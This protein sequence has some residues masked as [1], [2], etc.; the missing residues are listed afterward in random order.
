MLHLPRTVSSHL[1]HSAFAAALCLGLLAC[2]ESAE[3]AGPF[4]GLDGSAPTD[5]MTGKDAIGTSDVT[6]PDGGAGSDGNA[7]VDATVV[8]DS[9]TQDATVGGEDAQV[10]KDSGPP[11]GIWLS[12]AS[13]NG[14]SD[15]TFANWRGRANEVAGTWCDN[16]IDDQVNL[17]STAPGFELDGFDAPIDIAVGAIY[18]ALGETWGK[19]AAGEYDDRWTQSLET[20]KSRRSGKGTTY[21]RFAHEF[22]GD[23]WP[24][25]W[26]VTGAE[27]SDFVTSW[28]RFR[29]LQK[30]VFPESKLVWCPN[31]GTSGAN[32]LDVRDAWPGDQYVD[33]VGVD[34]YNWWPF[35]YTADEFA[36]RLDKN[37][38][39]GAPHGLDTWRQF[40]EQKGLPLAICEWASTAV[41]KDG[42][43]GGDS[44]G[45]MEA[46]HAWLTAHGG[47]GPGQVEYEVLFNQWDNFELWPDTLQP[48]AAA[49]YRDLW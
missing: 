18:K 28:R 3:P 30:S 37:G 1:G 34:S 6:S 43:G 15:G 17:W 29:A 10:G 8:E 33:V 46:F 2:G 48:Q 26:M 16:S 9:A 13:G 12:G 32:N 25:R 47:T 39:N 40:A 44:P 5:S 7:P 23:W 20:L 45:Y 11:T 49:K 21:I 14:F 35:A 24:H 22:N 27:A 36:A 38:P 4:G 42:S 41:D 19:A 31:D